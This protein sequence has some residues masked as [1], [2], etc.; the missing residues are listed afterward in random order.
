MRV[1]AK[2]ETMGAKP[3]AKCVQPSPRRRSNLKSTPLRACHARRSV[4]EYRLAVTC[5]AP[6]LARMS[7]V[8]SERLLSSREVARLAGV[9][10]EAEIAQRRLE[11]LRELVA[12]AE[13][14]AVA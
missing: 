11:R 8:T 6:I 2:P 9:S 10:R 7:A 12:E 13:A 3:D 14:A 1:T 5:V 4:Y